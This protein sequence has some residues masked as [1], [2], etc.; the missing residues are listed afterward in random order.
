MARA[1]YIGIMPRITSENANVLRERSLESR[2][3]GKNKRIRELEGL[4]AAALASRTEDDVRRK[5]RLFA[6]VKK[7]DEMI[8]ECEEPKVFAQLVSAKARL[9][10]LL[11]PKPGSLRPKQNRAERAPI[12]PIQPLPIESQSALVA[13]VTDQNHNGEIVQS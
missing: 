4:L 9:W 2:F 3:E 1:R 8:E 12:Q 7:C 6:Q 10:E 11:Y 13:P 5:E